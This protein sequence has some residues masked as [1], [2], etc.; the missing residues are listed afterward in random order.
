MKTLHTFLYYRQPKEMKMKRC[1]YHVSLP[2]MAS[3]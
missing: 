1:A 2:P 3:S